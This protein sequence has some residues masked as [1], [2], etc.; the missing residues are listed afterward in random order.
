M[1]RCQPFLLVI[2]PRFVSC[3]PLSLQFILSGACF[4]YFCLNLSKKYFFA[5]RME[6][7]HDA[8]CEVL[9]DH[10][11]NEVPMLSFRNVILDLKY[12]LS[13]C[14][15]VQKIFLFH[16]VSLELYTSLSKIP[17]LMKLSF[18]VKRLRG[19]VAAF[20]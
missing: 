15:R 3:F 8:L 19:M 1:Q 12:E 5:I 4:I 13:C 6:P 18:L 14:C 20:K 11:S 17:S 7:Q 9:Q 2:F 16:L 10:H